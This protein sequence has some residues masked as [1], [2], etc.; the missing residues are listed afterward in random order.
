MQ[1]SLTRDYNYKRRLTFITSIVQVVEV[2]ERNRRIISIKDK[3]D[4][5]F[6]QLVYK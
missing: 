5:E 2:V 3:L 4:F 1:Q 6:E